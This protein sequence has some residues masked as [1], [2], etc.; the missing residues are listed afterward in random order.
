[1]LHGSGA[2]AVQAFPDFV[3][4][5]DGGFCRRRVRTQDSGS[6]SDSHGSVFLKSPVLRLFL[7][8]ALSVLCANLFFRRAQSVFVRG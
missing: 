4:G 2:N 8:D 5:G 1:M 3:F 6:Q 7:S